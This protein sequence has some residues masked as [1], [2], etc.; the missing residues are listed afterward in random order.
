[1]ILLFNCHMILHVL[2]ILGVSCR[3]IGFELCAISVLS[4]I[5]RQ[6]LM[7]VI[8]RPYDV[9]ISRL[10]VQQRLV[11]YYPIILNSTVHKLHDDKIFP[12]LLKHRFTFSSTAENNPR[13]DHQG[14]GINIVLIPKSISRKI[15]ETEPSNPQLFFLGGP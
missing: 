6:C 7:T 3:T 1:M 14:H 15:H 2:L 11:W 13:P 9:N 8:C 4:K 12:F 10:P 5:G